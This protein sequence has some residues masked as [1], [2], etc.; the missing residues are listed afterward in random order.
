MSDSARIEAAL[1]RALQSAQDECGPPTL[2]RALRHAVVPGG[3]RVRPRLAIAVARACGDDSPDLTAAAAASIEL[4]HC[5]SLVHDDLPC[6]DNS[7]LRRGRAS[8]HR[9]FGEAIA[10]LAGDALI[11]LAFESLLLCNSPR[12]A[13]LTPLLAILARAAG[14]PRGIAAGQAWESEPSVHLESY[15]RAKTGALFSAA[16]AVGACAAGADP[17]EWR[18]L[19]ESLGEAYQIA[20]D[21]RDE[22]SSAGEIGKPTGKDRALAR[23][24]AVHE[25]G[26]HGAT[27]KLWTLATAALD[28]VPSCPGRNELRG[29]VSA[30]VE[31]L[32]PRALARPAA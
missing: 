19:G 25:L 20:D 4:L 11:V 24:N 18:A 26:A 16:T 7:P 2:Q 14:S 13:R 29:F 27:L 17:S 8:V 9:A 23:P 30:Q 10:V 28:A 12:T 31:R 22:F 6:F 32:I 1:S 15:Q 3:A 21:L 5:A